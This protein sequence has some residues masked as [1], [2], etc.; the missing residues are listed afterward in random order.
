MAIPGLTDAILQLALDAVGME[1]RKGDE[2]V[3]DYVARIGA[4][5]NAQR[6]LQ[7]LWD[8]AGSGLL[9]LALHHA[10]SARDHYKD[11]NPPDSHPRLP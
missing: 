2:S 10:Q 7:G 11:P 4:G 8:A 6:H 3:T 9:Q 5:P 1:P